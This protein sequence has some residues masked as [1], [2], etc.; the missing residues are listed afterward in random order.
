MIILWVALI[1]LYFIL[2]D[3]RSLEKKG[4]HEKYIEY[5]RKSH[6]I[7]ICFIAVVLPLLM[8]LSAWIVSLLTGEL[9]EEVQLGYIVVVLIVLVIP[10]KFI[11]ERI[12]QRRIRELALE[13]HE[14]VAVD[15]NYK[16]LH[17]I[18]NPLWEIILGPAALLYG[19]YFLQ[20]EQWVVYLFLLIP[21]FMYLN[22]RGTRYQTRPY[23]R[24]NYKYM[25]SFNIFNFLF[26][27]LYFCGYYLLKLQDFTASL[28]GPGSSGSFPESMPSLFLLLAGFLIILALMARVA[29]YLAN[30][31]AFNKAISGDHATPGTSLLRKVIF[32][33]VGLFILLAIS[34][35]ALM[36]GLLK[37]SQME[38][39]VVSEKYMIHRHQ[40]IN[41]T[42]LVIDQTR[43]E[44]FVQLNGQE[45]PGDLKMACTVRLSRSDREKSYDICCRSIFQELPVGTIVKFEYA[46]GPAITR[47]VDY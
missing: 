13:T 32:L 34:G 35:T 37:S 42:L 3:R 11:D 5:L 7:R 36:T 46:P 8:L 26:F 47:L 25:F 33:A 15:L 12:T 27:L 39:G 19:V 20:I 14:K 10:F 17:M 2:T 29:V 4:H 40:G 38:V 22:I 6:L 23:L 28:E 45:Y 43:Q 31:R 44:S 18:Y 41:D 9:K 21:W 16:T 1:I 24:D 30:Y